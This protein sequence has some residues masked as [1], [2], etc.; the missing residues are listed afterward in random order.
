MVSCFSDTCQASRYS[1][2]HGK[3]I[4]MYAS[5]EWFRNRTVLVTGGSGFVGAPLVSRLVSAGADVHVVTRRARKNEAERHR[6][7]HLDMADPDRVD[8]VL[9]C[10]R[11][12]VVFHLASRVTGS[13]SLGEVVPTLRDNVQS[14]VNVLTAA[15]GNGGPHV[16]MAGSVEEPR[17]GDG[18]APP[19]SPYAVAK[20]VSTVYGQLFADLWSLPVTILRIAMVYGPAQPDRKK[21]LPYVME[22]LLAGRRPQLTSGTRLIDWIYIDDVVDALLTAACRREVLTGAR[23]PVDIGSGVGVSIRDTVELLATIIGKHDRIDYAA[24]PDR[25]LDQPRIADPGPASELLAWRVSTP[26][27]VGLQIMV[28]RYR[29]ETTD[30]DARGQEDSP[31]AM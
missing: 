29:N 6:V 5:I 4:M 30:G 18:S 15:A 3:V 26:L 28:D 12:E 9:A 20:W 8:H 13:R 17:T 1:L 31:I 10:A 21:L 19:S 7:W 27:E 23:T 16:V 24:L 22:S 11:P 14:T 25:R 2:A